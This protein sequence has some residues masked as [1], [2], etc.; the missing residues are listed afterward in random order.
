MCQDIF[1]HFAILFLNF[2]IR[3][4]PIF[5]FHIL[6]VT[7]PNCLLAT[8]EKTVYNVVEIKRCLATWHL[9]IKLMN[10]RTSIYM[11]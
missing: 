8:I 9:I 2:C 3:V 5:I 4:V 11:K 10:I 1:S 6:R 7:I